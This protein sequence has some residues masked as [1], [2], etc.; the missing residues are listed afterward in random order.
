MTRSRS[1]LAGVAVVLVALAVATA[2]RADVED[3]NASNVQDG[4]NTSSSSQSGEANSGEAIGGQVSGVVSGGRASIDARNTSKDSDV[5]TGDADGSNSASNFVGLNASEGGA[6]VVADITNVCAEP[7]EQCDNIQEGD[8]RLSLTQSLAVNSGDGV[9][10]QVLGLVAF[11][12]ADPSIV[13][14]NTTDGVDV[15]TGEADGT[16]DSAAFVGLNST[17][18]GPF[19]A[20]DITGTCTTTDCDNIQEGDNRISSRQGASVHSGDGVA[21]QVI[22]AI[23]NDDT[24]VDATNHTTDSSVDTGDAGADNSAAYFAGLNSSEFGPSITAS[25]IVGSCVDECDNVQEGDNRVSTAQTAHATSGDGVAGSVIGVVSTGDVSVAAANSTRDTDITTGDADATNDLAAFVGL[26][27]TDEGGGPVITA[28]IS[29]ACIGGCFNL[30]EGDNRLTGSQAARAASGDGVGGQVLGIVAAGNASLDA[31]NRS[32]GVGVDTG[33]ADA[34]NNAAVFVG[35]NASTFGP[36]ITASDITFVTATNLQD[37]DNRKTLT[38]NSDATSGDAVAGQVSG[39]VTGAGGSASVVLANH[40]EDID[41]D[42]GDSD[43]TNE[44]SSFVGLNVSTE[45]VVG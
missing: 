29:D 10:G 21:G 26:N 14:S 44:E 31:T 19:I 41:A 25:D 2:A 27:A 5:G 18:E 20:A 40:S 7:E 42:S 36:T 12:A 24:S 11:R 23:T 3:A 35:L 45:T 13:A 6:A 33:D 39:V 22:G 43:F 30:Q 32:V 34:H 28:D 8:N 37:G 9:G 15:S 38:Q 4:R 1:V 16:N 17:D